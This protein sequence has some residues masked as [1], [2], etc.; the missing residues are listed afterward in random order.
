MTYYL[1]PITY[2]LLPI[3]YYLLPITYY[4]LIMYLLEALNY[5]VMYLYKPT[6]GVAVGAP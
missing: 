1:L 2:Y 6:S 3:T 5:R 4:L